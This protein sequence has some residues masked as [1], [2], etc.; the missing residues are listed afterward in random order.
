MLVLTPLNAAPSAP[1]PSPP[2]A[3]LPVT[4]GSGP[5]TLA[6]SVSEDAYQGDAQFTVSVDGSQI[7][8]T[9][10][11]TASHASGQ[12]QLFNVE[13]SFGPGQHTVS[14]DFLNDDYA[15]TAS[16]DRN[17]YVANARFNGAAVS[18]GALSELSAGPQS[19]AFAG[20]AAGQDTLQVS[21]S[22]DAWQGDAQCY[23]SIDGQ[24]LGGPV[25]VTAS[26]AQGQAQ[27]LTYTGN[28][29]AGAHSV[30]IQFINDAWGGSDAAD[31]N[32]YV[33]NVSLDGTNAAGAPAALL[34]ATTDTF[35]V[36]T[37]NGNAGVLASG[38]STTLLSD[39]TVHLPLLGHS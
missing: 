18:G 35:T 6:L 21:L 1:T 22:E 30:G 4:L 13:G 36:N 25:S 28:W 15:G 39:A 19:F 23:V 26:H 9:Q 20:H 29:A 27:T 34:H 37:S 12:S 10:T 14:V 33:N 2:A 17:L 7:G 32:L 3:P 38:T 31:R 16:T 11:A 24:A 5:D 8:A